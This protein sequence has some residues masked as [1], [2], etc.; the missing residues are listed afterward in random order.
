MLCG[1]YHAAG[2][3]YRVSCAYHRFYRV[4]CASYVIGSMVCDVQWVIWREH[5]TH[6]PHDI[7]YTVDDTIA[8]GEQEE[9]GSR[10]NGG[11]EGVKS[12]GRVRR[13]RRWQGGLDCMVRTMVVL[14][15]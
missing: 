6:M 9:R 3:I 5:T 4:S 15:R 14:L 8:L 1:V 2:A 13:W 10:R 11:H 12:S 7:R